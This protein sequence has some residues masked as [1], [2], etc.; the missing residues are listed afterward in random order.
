MLLSDWLLR[1]H[2]KHAAQDVS[3]TDFDTYAGLYLSGCSGG[4]TPLPKKSEPLTDI[5]NEVQGVY[6]NPSPLSTLTDANSSTLTV[7]SITCQQRSLF[8]PSP[9]FKTFD[10][11]CMM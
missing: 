4:S 3:Q 11:T 5:C 2:C 6:L 10:F 7:Y 8:G 1:A 9:D